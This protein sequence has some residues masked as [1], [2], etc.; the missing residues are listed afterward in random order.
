LLLYGSGNWDDRIQ[1]ENL[2]GL[3][4]V[5]LQEFPDT[6]EHN[7]VPDVARRGEFEPLLTWLMQPEPQPPSSFEQIVRRRL[8]EFVAFFTPMPKAR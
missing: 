2:R 4:C 8:A 7:I 6:G 1:A 3:P 5:T